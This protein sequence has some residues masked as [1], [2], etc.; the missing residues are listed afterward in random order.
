MGR[1]LKFPSCCRK[2]VEQLIINKM[3]S[4]RNVSISL[5]SLQYVTRITTSPT[6]P[7]S[8]IPIESKLRRLVMERRRHLPMAWVAHRMS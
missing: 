5:Q 6:S 7:P 3:R 4:Q 2:Y 1:W 8:Q